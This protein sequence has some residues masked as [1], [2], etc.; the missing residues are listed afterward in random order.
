MM[1]E[2]VLAQGEPVEGPTP[3]TP[4][5]R[6]GSRAAIVWR[7]L[8]RNARFW[9]GASLLVLLLLWA[10]AG[11]YL[12]QWRASDQDTS[13]LLAPPMAGHW[14]GTDELGHDVYA[15]VMSGLGV[16]LTVGFI[17]GLLAT[18][19]A[20]IIG[21]FAGYIG[22]IGDAIITWFVNLLLVIPTFFILIIC[23]P[24]F[25]G[26]SYWIIAL[27]FGLTGWMI[28]SQVIRAQTRALRDR[29]YVR[30]ARF[31]GF[32]PFSVVRRHIIPN[33]AS[34]LIVD[35]ALGIGGVILAETTLS[36]FGFGIQPPA[37]S[38]GG[39]IFDGSSSATTRPWLFM[40]PGFTL[41]AIL[42]SLNLLGDALRDA[43]D[44]TSGANR[45]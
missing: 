3:E 36:I 4:P 26:E 39:L 45:G 42:F 18:A 27:F 38:L 23:Y 43:I 6:R 5:G 1:P 32:P 22:G 24:F 40:F 7:T 34:L 14:F 20:A 28:T 37:V 25:R 19:L 12:W 35:A 44:P 41:V 21:A 9:V 16:S 30:A 15:Q 33:V 8:R 2:L 10:V 13:W 17:G 29:D 31:M 11:P